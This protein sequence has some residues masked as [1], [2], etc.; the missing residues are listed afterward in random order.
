M[1]QVQLLGQT[2]DLTTPNSLTWSGSGS[3]WVWTIEP[4]KFI[5]W[6]L[7]SKS[8]SFILHSVLQTLWRDIHNAYPSPICRL[9]YPLIVQIT[10]YVCLYARQPFKSSIT[11]DTTTASW[12]S[13][14]QLF[15][16]ACLHSKHIS[17]VLCIRVDGTAYTK[18]LV[19]R[20]CHHLAP[21]CLIAHRPCL[22]PSASSMLVSSSFLNCGPFAVFWRKYGWQCATHHDTQ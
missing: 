11:A 13:S 10:W 8:H 7:P 22:H 4:C 5:Y 12:V 17:K 1:V 9:S 18:W 19:L 3:E 14:Q 15:L 16:L 6:F 21:C 2:L 20:S